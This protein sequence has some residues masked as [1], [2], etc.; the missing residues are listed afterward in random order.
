MDLDL[1]AGG[2]VLVDA[3]PLVYL[4]EGSG[5]ANRR[6]RAVL[7]FMT[8]VAARG[9]SIIASTLLW[10][11]IL[12]GPLA[13]KDLAL[14]ARYRALLADSSRIVL[15]PLDAAI[16]EEAARLAALRGLSREDAVHIATARVSGAAAVLT[17]DEAWRELPEC[18]RLF[19]VDELAFDIDD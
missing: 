13:R 10:T 7:A 1:A 12:E 2:V 6:G 15:V 16:A 5:A 4:I 18:P 11:E 19:L 9:A 17:N 8:E 3:A 14:A